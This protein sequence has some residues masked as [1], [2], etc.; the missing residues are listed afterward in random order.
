MAT[1]TIITCDMHGDGTT[2]GSTTTFGLDGTTYQIDLCDQHREELHQSLD[3]FL[4]LARTSGRGGRSR[5]SGAASSARANGRRADLSEVREW[6]RSE[7][8]EISSRG[9][10]PAAI[11][12]AYDAAHTRSRGGRRSR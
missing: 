3:A 12:E 10:I 11:L 1:Q 8:Y 6:A 7:G 2:P 5:S 9:R 4:A